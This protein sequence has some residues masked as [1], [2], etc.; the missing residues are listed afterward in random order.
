[1]S[2]VQ[3]WRAHT[4]KALQMLA[5]S[6]AHVAQLLCALLQ[7]QLVSVDL[8][9]CLQTLKQLQE[10]ISR[11][12]TA[13]PLALAADLFDPCPT[14]SYAHIDAGTA[15]LSSWYCGAALGSVLLC[16]QS[17]SLAQQLCRQ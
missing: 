13:A 7:A 11:C 5:A 2:V 12:S 4:D 9:M 3:S 15:G 8:G 17:N 6:P 1:M 10:V 16:K 14:M